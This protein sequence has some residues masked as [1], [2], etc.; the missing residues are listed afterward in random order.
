MFRGN[1]RSRLP[2]RR[3]AVVWGLFTIHSH[4]LVKCLWYIPNPWVWNISSFILNNEQRFEQLAALIV[5]E[6]HMN[7]HQH[8]EAFFKR[9]G[10][11]RP[12]TF[13]EVDMD[14]LPLINNLAAKEGLTHAEVVN[15]L[16][17]FA[18]GEQHMAD[19]NLSLWETLTDREK[20]TA[21]LTCL[22]Y[23][24]HEIA[25]KMVISA[26]TVKTHLRSVLQKFNVNS[27]AELQLLLASWDF[28]AWDK[29]DMDSALHFYP[30]KR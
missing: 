16:L 13:A 7:L 12:E 14:L 26:N 4:G 30:D 3:K 11:I 21:A 18:L 8:F 22:G 23:T 17:S 10:Y 20:E 9:L 29:P 25:H 27:K 1:G 6:S 2:S 19:E 24:N 15:Q 5:Q 28:R